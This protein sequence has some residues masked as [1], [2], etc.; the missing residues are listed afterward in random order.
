MIIVGFVTVTESFMVCLYILT[1]G[2]LWCEGRDVGQIGS[3]LGL[4]ASMLT[5]ST[6]GLMLWWLMALRENPGWCTVPL[7]WLAAPPPSLVEGDEDASKPL[8]GAKA[9]F[10]DYGSCRGNTWPQPEGCHRPS[11]ASY[12][13]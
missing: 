2:C 13:V 3:L 5:L 10:A 12:S 1:L 4:T 9:E 8:R 6:F 11:I 7:E